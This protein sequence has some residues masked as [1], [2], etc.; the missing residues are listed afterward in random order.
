M[1]AKKVK[2]IV[3]SPF[4]DL[5]DKD[6]V[7][8]PDEVYPRPANKKVSKER[9]EELKTKKSKKTGRP[10]IKEVEEDDQE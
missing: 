5:E 4:K 3:L 2:Y 1:T 9:L 8:Q 10:F 6:K 7:Y